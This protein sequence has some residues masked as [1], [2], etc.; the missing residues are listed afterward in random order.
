MS[1]PQPPHRHLDASQGREVVFCHACQNEWYRDEQP[2]LDCPRCQGEI[3]EIVSASPH[4][5]LS[6][7]AVLTRLQVTPEN[8]PRDLDDGPDLGFGRGRAGHANYDDSD[9]DPEE[10]DIDQHVHHTGNGFLMHRTIRPGGPAN[11]DDPQQDV[12]RR[13]TDMLND[14]HP[15]PPPGRSGQA[16]LFPQAPGGDNP[17]GPRGGPSPL[18]AFT[19]TTFRASPFGATVTI[20]AVGGVPGG[21]GGPL[22]FDSYVLQPP[23]P[24]REAWV[25][26]RDNANVVSSV[27][28]DFMND[29]PEANE[30]NHPQAR[31]GRLATGPFDLIL[32]NVLAVMLGQP[33][34]GVHGDAVYSQ[35]ALD[36]IISQLMEAHPNSARAPPPASEEAIAKLGKRKV[37]IEDLGSEGKAECTICIEELHVGDEVTVLPCKHWF[38]GEC[39]SLWLKEHNTCPI[40]RTPIEAGRRYSRQDRQQEQGQQEGQ[41]QGQQPGQQEGQ[42]QRP[43]RRSSAFNFME[44]DNDGRSSNN[45]AQQQ[46]GSA[47]GTPDQTPSDSNDPRRSRYDRLFRSPSNNEERLNAIRNLAGASYRPSPPR[48]TSS[49]QQPQ[50]GT[51][52]R[53]NSHSPPPEPATRSPR[54]RSP[55]FRSRNPYDDEPRA[56]QPMSGYDA[57]A[58][59]R[60]ERDPEGEGRGSGPLNWLRGQWSRHSGSGSGSGNG[61]S[62]NGTGSG[63][64][65]RS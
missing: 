37:D 25:S 31:Q 29:P 55:E 30:P 48:T 52:Q 63:D 13:F 17:D 50:Q 51:F 4:T 42:Q 35:E 16:T 5:A 9:S 64:A 23:L 6:P 36:R 22:G 18:P 20:H 38:H 46:Y 54:V 57:D 8:D 39:V 12:I 49:F 28:A 40:C 10:A 19:R 47:Q 41:Q 33:P 43:Q 59:R 32:Q 58:Y 27:F 1:G 62:G 61:G 14:F 24:Q 65:K 3:T 15:G 7:A 26:I 56:Q 2:T 44:S 34:G 53:R 45:Q 11:H 21:R 60:R